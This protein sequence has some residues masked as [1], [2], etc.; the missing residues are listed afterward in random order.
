MTKTIVLEFTCEETVSPTL[1]LSKIRA[2]C[3]EGIYGLMLGDRSRVIEVQTVEMLPYVV[4]SDENGDGEFKDIATF[5]F[6][7]DA[8]RYAEA[9][10]SRYDMTYRIDSIGNPLYMYRKGIVEML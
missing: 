1:L 7:S 10:T 5:V 2:V 4:L 8:Q 3:D 9:E 6:L